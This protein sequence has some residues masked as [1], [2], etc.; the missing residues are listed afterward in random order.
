M[1]LKR[2][3]KPLPFCMFSA[4]GQKGWHFPHISAISPL[5]QETCRITGNCDLWGKWVPGALRTL[6]NPLGFQGIPA[7]GPVP[8]GNAEFHFSHE[9]HGITRKLRKSRKS[10]N[11]AFLCVLR[12]NDPPESIGI[13]W[14][15]WC[16]EGGA[17]EGPNFTKKG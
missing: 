14:F 6:W 11:F 12:G 4:R 13:H 5:F 7:R 9:F 10:R 8:S 3:L 15:R 16:S 17:R 2:L 1:D